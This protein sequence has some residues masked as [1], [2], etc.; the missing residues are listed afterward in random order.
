LY[1]YKKGTVRANAPFKIVNGLVDTSGGGGTGGGGGIGGSGGTGGGIGGSGGT[2]G[3]IGGSGGTGGGI[4][5][6]GG[7]T[8]PSQNAGKIST[9]P[10]TLT[11]EISFTT[12]GAGYIGH[13]ATPTLTISGIGGNGLAIGYFEYNSTGGITKATITNSGS[14]YTANPTVTAGLTPPPKN[15]VKFYTTNAGPATATATFVVS[16]VPQTGAIANSLPFTNADN[17]YYSSPTKLVGG[18][19]TSI[20]TITNNPVR[21]TATAVT[22]AQGVVTSITITNNTDNGFY[23]NDATPSDPTNATI[24]SIGGTNLAGKTF[25]YDKT[26]ENG[27]WKNIS[28]ISGA[29]NT[30]FTSSSSSLE[31][32]LS[33]PLQSSADTAIITPV[34]QGQ[35]GSITNLTLTNAGSK[36][37]KPSI[38]VADSNLV[39]PVAATMPTLYRLS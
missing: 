9:S 2:G 4:G 33:E 17:G 27:I 11:T 3:G 22:N 21:A 26:I 35:K 16:T 39:N 6:S 13:N 7:G 1:I 5:G 32:V 28:N 14:G 25:T 19:P 20:V 37:Y 15:P 34:L 12:T 18:I 23:Y 38:S 29:G 36:Y 8:Q 31:V 24:V 10:T 30:G